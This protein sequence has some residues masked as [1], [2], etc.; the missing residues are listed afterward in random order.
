VD[1]TP[2]GDSH[3][4]LLTSRMGRLFFTVCNH[5]SGFV[6]RASI[7]FLSGK[8]LKDSEKDR[9]LPKTGTA[10]DRTTEYAILIDFVGSQNARSPNF[11][12]CLQLAL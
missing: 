7:E 8:R 5:K 3:T 10:V 2:S 6:R 4:S 11:F 1:E 12:D 9:N